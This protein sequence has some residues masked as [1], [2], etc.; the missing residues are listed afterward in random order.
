MTIF[1]EIKQKTGICQNTVE[2]SFKTAQRLCKERH[3]ILNREKDLNK[4]FVYTL[5]REQLPENVYLTDEI[6]EKFN[7]SNN[8]LRSFNTITKKSLE[9]KGIYITKKGEGLKAL[10]TIDKIENVSDIVNEGI[11]IDGVQWP[12]I[13]LGYARDL[14]GE[15]FGKLTPLYRTVNYYGH[16]GNKEAAVQWVCKCDCGNYTTALAKQ[17]VTGTKRSCGCLW[18]AHDWHCWPFEDL[19]GQTFGKL[20]VIE[21]YGL[22]PT[23]KTSQWKCKCECGNE[24]I[25]T[26]QDLK[27]G[28]TKSCGCLRSSFGEFSIEQ[29][30]KQNNINYK[31][32]FS[33]PDLRSK[34]NN[35]LR[36][37]FAIFDQDNNLQYLIEYDGEQHFQ[38]QTDKIWKD[39]FETRKLRDQ[40]KNEYCLKNNIKLYRIPYWDKMKI[41]NLD[42]LTNEQYLIK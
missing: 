31:K 39:N 17:M 26:N 41:N 5:E 9:H 30:L 1:E 27:L 10:Y 16:T 18:E 15:K 38:A 19:T 36:F 2:K 22:H 7:L 4:K 12:E 14:K 8:Q 34:K 20:T 25:A 3:Y 40:I 6:K 33:F 28:D 11:I 23:R 21:Y 24:T 42:I 35:V 32:E 37:D 13:K 29:I